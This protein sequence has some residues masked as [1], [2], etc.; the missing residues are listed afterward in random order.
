MVQHKPGK[1]LVVPDTLS[2]MFALGIS[3]KSRGRPLHPFAGMYE[4]TLKNEQRELPA[5][6]RLPPT[7]WLT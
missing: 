3:K 4:M 7:N 2:R 6:I 1:L 5:L